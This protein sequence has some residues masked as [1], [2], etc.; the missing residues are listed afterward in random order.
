MIQKKNLIIYGVGQLGSRHLQG[1]AGLGDEYCIYAY[2]PSEESLATAQT[3]W[4]ETNG[5]EEISFIS[6]L[7]ELGKFTFNLAIVATNANHRLEAIQFLLKARTKYFILE[8]VLFQNLYDYTMAS[9]LFQSLGAEVYVN[10][11]RRLFGHYQDLHELLKDEAEMFMTVSGA[12]WGLACNAIHMIDLFS[13]LGAGNELIADTSGLHDGFFESKRQGYYEISGTMA[14]HSANRLKSLY[15]YS[16]K[17][18]LP[19]NKIQITTVNFKIELDE[20]IGELKIL[21]AEGSSAREISTPFQSQMTGDVVKAIFNGKCQ[22]TPF[23]ESKSLHLAMIKP[24][25]NFFEA[26]NYEHPGICPIT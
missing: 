1:L 3:R 11:P 21:S 25:T 20:S 14:V 6:S 17:Q 8:K 10:C 22:L 15:L 23:E 2:D 18:G 7:S 4:D 16:G 12:N 24:L 19:G 13:F 5:T 9:D 26:H